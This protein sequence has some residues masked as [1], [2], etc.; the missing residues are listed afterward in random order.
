[1]ANYKWIGFTKDGKKTNGEIEAD[2]EKQAKMFLRRQGIKPREVQA[3]SP[4][5]IDLGRLLVD[6]GIIKP[7]KQ[8][9]LV[10]FTTQLSTL[11]NAG[12]PILEC[13]EILS[14]Q[15][16][17]PFL[18]S[19]I[20]KISDDVGGGKSLYEALEVHSSKGFG[21][22]Y[23]N[24]VK[25]GE[26]GG[27][28]DTILEK[29]GKHME[30]Q[31]RIRGAVKGAMMY[32]AIVSVVGTGV[33]IGL[34][35]F[36]VPQFVGMLTDSGQAIPWVTQVVIDTS[37]IFQKYTLLMLP[38]LAALI[39]FILSYIKTPE[40]KVIY[41]R[42]VMKTP[43]FGQLVVKSN[44]ASFTRTLSTMLSSGVSI[45]ESLEICIETLDNT[46][47]AK[48]IEKVRKAVTEGKSI[49]E[50]LTRISYFPDLVAQMIKVGESTGNL[51]SMLLK[52]SDVFERELEVIIGTLTKMI[53]PLILVGLGG[54]IGFVMIAMYL[55][56]FMSAGGAG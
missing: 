43:M 52:V 41:D 47:I 20:K 6:R 37:E 30:N 49:T 31:E 4:F 35:V 19:I 40:G 48:D 42:V 51:D 39:I 34:M 10:K 3:P 28:L 14:K 12:V 56:M 16:K 26:A 27:I 54:V 7:F 5:E 17:N 45:I 9:E 53:E 23:V 18:K 33:V 24:L 2:S 13:M 38:I 29:L 32:P 22:L 11:I 55:P 1:M 25:A 36:V 15:Q 46:Q 44:L 8:E 21:K 50:P